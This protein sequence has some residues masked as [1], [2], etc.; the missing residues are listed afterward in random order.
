MRSKDNEYKRIEGLIVKETE[1]FK[2]LIESSDEMISIHDFDGNYLYYYGPQKYKIYPSDIIGKSPFDFFE[3]KI[4][5]QIVTQIKRTAETGEKSKIEIFTIWQGEKA[6]FEE[7]IFPLV[8]NGEIVAVVKICRNINEKKE[9]EHKLEEQKS[10]FQKIVNSFAHPLYVINADTYEIEFTNDFASKEDFPEGTKCFA[11]SYETDKPCNKGNEYCPINILKYTKQPVVAEQVKTDKNG[12]KRYFEI[13]GFPIYDETGKLKN[14]IEYKIDI[15]EKKEI[16]KRLREAK[17]KAEESETLKSAF[18]ANMSHEIR[19][20]LNGILGFSE[21]LKRKDLTED[22]KKY[23]INIINNSGNYLLNLIND[24]IDISR[25]DSGLMKLNETKINFNDFLTE[26]FEMFNDLILKNKKDINFIFEN[27]C[28]KIKDIVVD[29]MRLKQI[30]INLIGNAEKFTNE[31]EIRLSCIIEDNKIK[32]CLKDTGIGIE[33]DKIPFIFDRFRRVHSS[34]EELFHGTGLGL[35]ITKSC[36]NL[37]KGDIK[38]H[39][40]LG[41]GTEFTFSVPFKLVNN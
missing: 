26:I 11:F 10:F 2:Y 35:A 27:K 18:L 38:V 30:L 21:L 22:K 40:E 7:S 20:P 15:T 36:I 29:Y 19:T 16:E 31:G 37:L 28:S 3:K 41:K 12:E 33:K 4:A 34:S 25:F 17:I 13:H 1:L 5:S 9:V 6:W 14:V 23:Y 39:S 8:R 24:I 32:F